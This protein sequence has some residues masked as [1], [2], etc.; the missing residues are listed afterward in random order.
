MRNYLWHLKKLRFIVEERSNII[1]SAYIALLV[2]Q[3]STR[4]LLTIDLGVTFIKEVLKE[5]VSGINLIV[6]P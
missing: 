1:M 4:E 6:G 2:L 5:N 3:E